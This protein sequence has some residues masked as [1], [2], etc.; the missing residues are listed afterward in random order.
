M[1]CRQPLRKT[2]LI[3]SLLGLLITPALSAA[4]ESHPPHWTYSGPESPKH[5]GTLDPSYSLCSLGHM[6]SPID[7]RNAKPA[8]LPVLK[9]D[10]QAV[11]LNIIDNGHTIQVNFPPGSTLTVSDRTY[12]LKQVHFHHPGE[13]R[14]NGKSFPLVAHLVHADADGH[15]AVIAVLFE[16]GTANPLIDTLWK[17]IP[18]EKEKVQ[19]V[20]SVSVRVQDLLPSDR[21]YF[22]LAG[23]LTTPP[24]TEGVTWYVLKSH[25]TISPGQVAVFAKKYPMDARPVQPT[26][27]R[28]I[29]QSK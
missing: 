2:V 19:D 18:A 1:P 22:T 7:V 12:T 6:Q 9:I 20:P 21:G 23:S 4:Q 3:G 24:C 10:Y 26:N 17:N 13:E 16:P 14:I 25:P 29:L 15:L 27:G 5:W 11:P 8:D 28:E